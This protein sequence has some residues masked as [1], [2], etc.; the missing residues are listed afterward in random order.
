MQLACQMLGG[1]VSR[2]AS[3]EFGR[4]TLR[5]HDADGLFAGVPERNDR[6]DEP[7]RPG[8][9]RQRRLR[10]AGRHRHL[11]GR[12]RPAPDPAG[13]RPAVPPGGQPHARTAADPRATSSTT[14]AA[15]RAC[16]RCSRS[17]T[18]RSTELRERVGKS[19]VICGLSGGVDSSVS[20]A[21]LLKAIGPQVACIFVDNGLLREGEAE[22][23]QAHLPRLVQGRPARRRRRATG[24]SRRWRASPTR[25]RSGKIIGHVFIDVFKDEAKSHPGRAVPGPG[26]AVPGR[27][28]ERRRR[29]R[30][31]GDDQDAPQRR[32]PAGGTRASS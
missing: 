25:R 2:R 9:G 32:R 18:G 26:D 27:D 15:A 19:R 12:R 24:S 7:R 4:A 22:A 31:G 5:V 29:G 6:L 20:A 10:A 17:S 23:V 30:P 11:P 13:L 28:R 1:E 8:A 14:S 16:G 3:R 21:L